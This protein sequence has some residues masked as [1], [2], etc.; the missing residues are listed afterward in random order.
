[1]LSDLLSSDRLNRLQDL[2]LK[3]KPQ[4]ALTLPELFDTL[5]AGIWAEVM[6]GK[7]DPKSIQISSLRRALQ[8]QYMS[9]LT[10][11]TLRNGNPRNARSFTEFIALTLTGNAPE[12]ARSIAWYHLRQLKE[13]IASTLSKQGGNLDT[14]TKIHLEESSDRLAKILDSRLQAQ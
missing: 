6:P 11:M 14:Y 10:N 5:Q 3:T 2:E 13:A 9:I 1:M 4:A 8:R 12:D 7:S